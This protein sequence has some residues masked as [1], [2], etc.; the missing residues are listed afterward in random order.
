MSVYDAVPAGTTYVAGSGHGDLR[1]AQNVRDEFSAVAYTNNNGTA[2]WAGG[3]TE[4]DALG[5]GAASGL[6]LVTGGELQ[7]SRARNVQDEFTAVAYTNNNGT[8]SWSAG[9]TETDALGGGAASGLVLVTGNQLQLNRARNVRDDFTTAAYTNNNGTASWA[10]G[11]TETD[12]YGTGPSGAGTGAAGGFVRVTGGASGALQFRYLLSTVADQFTVASYALNTGSDNWYDNWTETGDDG[13]PSPPQGAFKPRIYISSGSLVLAEA[14]GDTFGISRAADVAFGSNVTVSFV[15]TNDGLD[16]GDQIVAEYIVNGVPTALATF[17]GGT[18]GWSGNVQT[19]PITN[20]QGTR[21]TLQ[22]RATGAWGNNDRVAIDNV[23][24]SYDSPASAS[25]TLVRRTADL[26][27]AVAAVLT[28]GY[29]GANLEAGDTLVVEASADGTNFTVLETLDGLNGSGTKAYNVAPTNYASAKTTIRLRV[30]SGINDASIATPETFSV[31]YV[32]I[33][34]SLAAPD[35]RRAARPRGGHRRNARA[36]ATRAPTSTPERT[37]WWSRRARTARTSRSW[38][39]W[40]GRQAGR[41]RTTWSPT[42]R[43]A[44]RSDSG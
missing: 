29:T 20:V 22:F 27:G 37:P 36:S 1:A 30:T 42:P 35:V 31:D 8:A 34:Y 7:L 6:A 11:W 10:A 19:Y 32:D 41:R 26:T 12:A 21:I 15:P 14:T 39:P 25:G 5:G 17:D 3:W 44:P 24:V 9:W 38:R 40:T 18:A 28:F 16:G 33:I 4:T 2:S 13:S 23:Q 43:P